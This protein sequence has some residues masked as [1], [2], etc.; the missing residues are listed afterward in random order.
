MRLHY[1]KKS[2]INIAHNPIQHDQTRHVKVD[3]YFVKEKLESG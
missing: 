2:T 1:D 3:R